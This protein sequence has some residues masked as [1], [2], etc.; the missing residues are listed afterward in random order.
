M[1]APKVAVIYE[2]SDK[3]MI[4]VTMCPDIAI[5]IMAEHQNITQNLHSDILKALTFIKQHSIED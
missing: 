1:I 5:K 3:P 4:Q 2:A